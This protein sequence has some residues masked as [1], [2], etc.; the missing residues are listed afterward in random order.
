MSNT[1]QVIAPH[2]ERTIQ[3]GANTRVN[4][5]ESGHP[6]ALYQ[7]K[8]KLG[9]VAL[10]LAMAA[11]T[12]Y[13]TVMSVAGYVYAVTE[14][15]LPNPTFGSPPA[16]VTIDPATLQAAWN[17]F[18]TEYALIQGNLDIFMDTTPGSSNPASILSQL[19]SVPATIKSLDG[20][21]T[22]DF[23][24][25]D[26]TNLESLFTALKGEVSDLVTSLTTLGTSINTG[27][28]N[29]KTQANSGVLLEL[30]NV[31][32]TDI[33]GLTKAI[34]NA[35]TKIDSDNKKIIEEGVGAAV[36]IAVALVGLAN[37][38]NPFGW[39]MMAGGAVGAVFAIEEIES[40]KV[41]IG[42]LNNTIKADT[43]WD[44][45]YSTSATAI[46]ATIG[47]INGF[48]S[49]QAAAE[50]E[51]QSLENV[52]ST[53]SGDIVTA[54]A[55]L[56]EATPDWTDAQKEWDEIMAVA[57]NLANIT[58]YVWP[59]PTELSNPTGL[60]SNS[61]GLYQV[62]SSGLA[63]YL[64]AGGT[65]WSAV[66]D[67]TLSIV[68]GGTGNLVAGI[69][70][71]PAVGAAGTDPAYTT[72]YF[73]R[74]YDQSSNAWTNIST[75]P[76]AQ[77]ATNGTDIYAIDQTISTRAVNKYNGSGTAWTT[78]PALPGIDAARDIAVAGSK[79]FA[80]SINSQQIYYYDGTS[81]IA[82]STTLKFRNISGNGDYLGV[83]DTNNSSYLWN[84]STNQFS[85]LSGTNPV[86][87]D[88][89]VGS[90]AQLSNGN[91][92]IINT[93]QI[94]FSLDNSTSLST[95]TQQAINVV[96]ITAVGGIYRVDADGSAYSTDAAYSSW[97]KLPVNS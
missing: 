87:T 29:L 58:A 41:E 54:V 36:A 15:K 28:T 64:V 6:L 61:T 97:T 78:L 2:A 22:L 10:D 38:W 32:E 89:S 11:S 95:A 63:S 37:F 1:L 82:I 92:L 84:A 26:A 85:N 24:T 59:G 79:V 73:A 74:T 5:A 42:D 23:A 53:L 20:A 19:V 72:N 86:A 4:L 16:G 56:K 69:N 81:W 83:V 76:A 52:L 30:Y 71:A 48:S 88:T 62:S 77:V 7:P 94:L 65:T 70:G 57:A 49:M 60:T 25:K 80:L 18:N 96:G 90:L 47:S 68:T 46:Q 21:I 33:V 34:A 9:A 75:F 67:K 14:L 8:T 51:L 93:S 55:D 39:V 27:S 40:L 35:Q 43:L 12:S 45:N 66:A 31:Y 13:L 44:N 50:L 3:I 91:Q 17:A